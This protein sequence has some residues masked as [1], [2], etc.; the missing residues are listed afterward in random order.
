MNKEEHEILSYSQIQ[1]IIM[2]KIDI[3]YR[4]NQLLDSKEFII[5]K[6]AIQTPF[7]HIAANSSITNMQQKE[8]QVSIKGVEDFNYEELH[9]IL[10]KKLML[11]HIEH[12]ISHKEFIE[13]SKPLS[14][15]LME[16]YLKL[17]NNQSRTDSK[18]KSRRPT[19]YRIK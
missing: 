17:S 7:H 12:R 2:Q 6:N 4:E 3:D 16:L 1:K 8:N 18:K 19:L 10:N 15:I 11:D 13:Y 9:D 14:L 5:F